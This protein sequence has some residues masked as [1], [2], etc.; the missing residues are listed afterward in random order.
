[1]AIGFIIGIPG[2]FLY[3]ERLRGVK[4]LSLLEIGKQQVEGTLPETAAVSGAPGAIYALSPLSFA[5]F[6]P[7]GLLA[8]YLIISS[9]FRI[10]A[11]YIDEAHGD[12]LLTIGDHIAT[13]TLAARETNKVR[14]ER[15]K[16]EKIDEPDRRYDGEWAGLK[17]VAFVIVS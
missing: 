3:L 13:R 11:A 6:T 5:L 1:M 10:A 12:P 8:T 4:E 17:D 14:V 9:I 15:A 16:L 2:Y 7:L